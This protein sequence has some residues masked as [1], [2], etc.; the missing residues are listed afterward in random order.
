M[1]TMNKSKHVFFNCKRSSSSSNNSHI[2]LSRSQTT[3]HVNQAIYLLKYLT[4]PV[5]QL[6]LKA[7]MAISESLNRSLLVSLEQTAKF[8]SKQERSLD[9]FIMNIIIVV[10]DISFWHM[11]YSPVR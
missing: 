1:P 6:A 10:T 2:C 11:A 7:Q 5:P 3:K 8:I 9:S 4:R